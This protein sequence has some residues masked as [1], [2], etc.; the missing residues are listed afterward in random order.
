MMPQKIN[1]EKM[2][3]EIK[4]L[5]SE[6]AEIPQNQIKDDARF[7]EDL[8]IDSMMA[9]EIVASIEKKYKIVIPEEKIPTINS[10]NTI[11]S[12][13]KEISTKKK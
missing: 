2:K 7:V 1:L 4:K 8:G 13:I 12:L 6:I 3:K 5:I 11:Y 9:L 10:L